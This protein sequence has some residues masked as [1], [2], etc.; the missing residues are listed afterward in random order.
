MGPVALPTDAVAIAGHASLFDIADLN[1]DVLARG[2]FADSLA[3]RGAKGVRMLSAHDEGAV[4]GVWDEITEDARGLFVQGRIMGW[5]AAARLAQ[6]LVRA[7]ALDG[8]SIG[9]RAQAAR[10]EGR[11]RVLTRVDL[12]EVS[13][14]TFPMLPG[15]RLR[16]HPG[17]LMPSSSLAGADP[18]GAVV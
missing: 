4:I 10:R 6:A 1:G 12:W 15:A 11:L 9:F 8:L 18:L 5:S 7:G 13:L 2:A 14:V 16:P 3:L 17:R